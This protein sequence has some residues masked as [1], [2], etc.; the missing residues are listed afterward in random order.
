M[1]RMYKTAMTV[2]AKLRSRVAADDLALLERMGL[3]AMTMDAKLRSRVAVDDLAL[4]KRMCNTAMTVIRMGQRC[5]AAWPV[6]K[7]AA[8]SDLSGTII[9][10]IM[11]SVGARAILG[12]HVSDSR[13][14]ASD[15][16]T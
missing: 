10:D 5:A 12:V 4:L 11:E 16:R 3:A 8:V 13:P 2:D 9:R 6:T 7:D 1:Q 14:A 15:E